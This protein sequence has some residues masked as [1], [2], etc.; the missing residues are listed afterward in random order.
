[1][2]VGYSKPVSE[3]PNHKLVENEVIFAQRNVD[4]KQRISHLLQDMAGDVPLLFFCECSNEDCMERITLDPNE[5]DA[6]HK[7]PRR[8]IIMPGH[9]VADVERVAETRATF[10]VVEKHEV[11]SNVTDGK[12]NPTDL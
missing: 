7:N 5:Y 9:D 3:T 12:L 1:M 4:L 11:P 10:V 6:I 8:F 2:S